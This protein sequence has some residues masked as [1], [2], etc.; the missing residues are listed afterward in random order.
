MIKTIKARF[1]GR[2]AISGAPIRAGD[3]VLFDT[4]TRK[5]WYGEP[6]D[7]DIVPDKKGSYLI[8]IGN[9]S[10]IRNKQGR[11]ID[12]PCCGCCTI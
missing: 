3:D 9:N 12:A 7:F 2:C 1:N 4:V 11:C 10:F 6:K 5:T 8:S